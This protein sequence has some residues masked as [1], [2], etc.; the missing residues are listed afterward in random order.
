MQALEGASNSEVVSSQSGPSPA[1]DLWMTSLL[2]PQKGRLIG[3]SK[4]FGQGR[5]YNLGTKFTDTKLD[6]IESEN[7]S[8]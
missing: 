6:N 7:K 3:R 8:Q 5:L 2:G 4:F 1:L